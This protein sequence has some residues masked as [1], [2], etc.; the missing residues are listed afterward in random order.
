MIEDLHRDAL[1]GRRPELQ[2]DGIVFVILPVA[3]FPLIVVVEDD[4][5][6]AG[7]VV[8]I[9]Q[10]SGKLNPGRI[11]QRAALTYR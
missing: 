7:V 9:V 10:N 6:L 2:F 4:A 8:E 5:K 3:P 11:L 1:R